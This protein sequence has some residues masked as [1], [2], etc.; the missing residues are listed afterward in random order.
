M[1]RADVRE[2][3]GLA[4]AF[5]GADAVVHLAVSPGY[6][7]E[8]EPILDLEVNGLGTLNVLRAALGAG[9]G[10]VVIGSTSHV[11]GPGPGPASEE[12][13]PRPATLYGVSKLTG[14]WYARL[15]AERGIRTIV[16]RMPIL[17]GPAA[18]GKSPP[19]VVARMTEAAFLGEPVV[20]LGDPRR[21]LDLL[22]VHDAAD[23]IVR[24]LEVDPNSGEV[25]NLGSGEGIALGELARLIVRTAG[26]SSV[27]REEP[28]AS[29]LTLP[30]LDTERAR[31]LLGF[32]PSVS[33]RDGVRA[34]V[35]AARRS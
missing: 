32:G 15:Y 21:K 14:D 4:D 16:L 10:R 23:G 20:V 11:Y 28:D 7:A 35:L 17:Y 5:R 12:A 22:H 29:A 27:I 26:S 25:V 33:V 1:I 24:A 19:N 31:R 2:P 18:S 3:E 13:T 8:Q 34:Y 30:M 6:R 9:V